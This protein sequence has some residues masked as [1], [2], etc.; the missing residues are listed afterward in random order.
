[1]GGGRTRRLPSRL[2]ADWMAAYI[3]SALSPSASFT[4]LDKEVASIK[5]RWRVAEGKL[6]L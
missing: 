1:M 4:V 6:E 2:S 3:A 5:T